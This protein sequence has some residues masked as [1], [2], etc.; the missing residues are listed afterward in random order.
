MITPN[1]V[2]KNRINPDME[3]QFKKERSNLIKKIK[4]QRAERQ[5]LVG[6]KNTGPQ[7]DAI[8]AQIN[9]TQVQIDSLTR[10]LGMT[11]KEFPPQ[12]TSGQVAAQQKKQNGKR[13]FDKP[14]RRSHRHNRIS[15]VNNLDNRKTRATTVKEELL[16]GN[17]V[18]PPKLW[19]TPNT[20]K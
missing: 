9:E 17:Y 14:Q 7:W 3:A 5:K 18:T 20:N 16:V 6:V 15:H 19:P 11:V 12:P 8:T 10:S 4:A 13:N 2:P 1:N